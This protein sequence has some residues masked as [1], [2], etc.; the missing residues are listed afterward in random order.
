MLPLLFPSAA[1]RRLPPPLPTLRR[2]LTTCSRL[3]YP[4][5]GPFVMNTDAEIQQAFRD[6][7]SGVLQRAEDNPWKDDE[8]L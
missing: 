2:P 7:Q 1:P 4:A 5:D 6:Y 8:E 3:P